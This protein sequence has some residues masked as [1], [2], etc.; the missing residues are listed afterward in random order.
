MPKLIPPQI[1][2]IVWPHIDWST[3]VR[4]TNEIIDRSP[5]RELD[6]AKI[7]VGSISSFLFALQSFQKSNRVHPLLK[8]LSITF[9]CDCDYKQLLLS[10]T[11]LKITPSPEGM[12][13]ISGTF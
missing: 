9:L 6:A 12:F 2:P 3:F 1:W 7:P 11:S 5:T 10:G 8:H 4:T 13:V